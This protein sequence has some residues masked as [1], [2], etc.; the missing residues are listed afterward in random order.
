VAV[1]QGV[2]LLVRRRAQIL[3]EDEANLWHDILALFA[4]SV[5]VRA[6]SSISRVK[7]A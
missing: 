4:A 7:S 3:Q 1:T 5:G 2:L 6:R